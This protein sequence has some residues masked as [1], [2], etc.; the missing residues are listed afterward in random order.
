[1]DIPL[2]WSTGMKT[3]L[4]ELEAP[5]KVIAVVTPLV[6]ELRPQAPAAWAKTGIVKFS[7]LVAGGLNHRVRGCS[8]HIQGDASLNTKQ[9][10]KQCNIPTEETDDPGSGSGGDGGGGGS[11]SSSSRSS[12]IRITKQPRLCVC[13]SLSLSRWSQAHRPTKAF[14]RTMPN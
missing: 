10:I 14:V 12:G 11:S 9:P 5:F 6:T 13:L 8:Y 4:A 7:E 1:M 2:A 3:A